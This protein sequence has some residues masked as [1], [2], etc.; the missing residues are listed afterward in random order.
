MKPQE[1]PRRRGS[2]PTPAAK[3]PSSLLG[4]SASLMA[5][6]PHLE[7]NGAKLIAVIMTSSWMTS[8]PPVNPKEDAYESARS[9]DVRRDIVKI[10]PR[11]RLKSS[12][13]R[14]EFIYQMRY[15]NFK[16]CVI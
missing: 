2:W 15:L 9:R 1:N 14:F 7:L 5:E 12:C 4:H 8:I 13:G 3:D 6:S 10:S 11:F 16:K